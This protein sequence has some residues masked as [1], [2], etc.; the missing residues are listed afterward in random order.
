[1]ALRRLSGVRGALA[2]SLAGCL[3]LPTAAATAAPRQLPVGARAAVEPAASPAASS[4][5]EPHGGLPARAIT[6]ATVPLLANF[7]R[8]E[9]ATGAVAA[10]AGGV[11][12][13]FGTELFGPPSTG[14]GPPQAD[15]F[16]ARWARRLSMSGRNRFLAG[17]TDVGGLYVLPVLPAIA[18]GLDSYGLFSRGRG[19]LRVGDPNPQH[20]FVAY[21]EAVGFTMLLTGGVKS[22]VGRARPYTPEALNRP[23]RR[24]QFEE[25]NLSFFSGHASISFATGAFVTADVSRALLV[26]PLAT[27]SPA[28]RAFLGHVLPTVVGYGVPTLVAVSRV[29]DLQHWP[30]DV[31]VGALVGGLMGQLA[32]T[33]HFDSAGSPLARFGGRATP[34]LI[35]RPD[36]GA[37]VGLGFGARF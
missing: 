19:F 12:M 3:A 4:S 35:A 5:H 22:V 13:L 21:V 2:W 29:A 30:S 20:R 7:S 14:M 27:A 36:G 16:D 28:S 8:L 10:A 32:Y 9:L 31:I 37:L 17:V 11:L 26:G 15:S 23:E 24:H 6:P 18:Y 25:D 1:M 33:W 34:V